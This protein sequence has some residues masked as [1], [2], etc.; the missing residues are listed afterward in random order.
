MSFA[1]MIDQITKPSWYGQNMFE[2]GKKMLA[3]E[4]YAW[5][6]KDALIQSGKPMSYLELEEETDLSQNQLKVGMMELVKNEEVS[7]VC[8][9]KKGEAGYAKIWS[10]AEWK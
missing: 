2:N 5:M 3:H 7:C 4:R 9:K 1:T 10:L 8:N 6:I